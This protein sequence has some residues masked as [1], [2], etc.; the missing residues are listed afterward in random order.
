[1]GFLNRARQRPGGAT[2]RLPPAFARP[3]ELYG[4]WQFDPTGSG[5]DP[6]Q[7]GGGNI[8]YEL[9]MLAQ[10]DSAAFI[11]SGAAIAI[12]AGG[13]ALYGGERAVM[14]SVGTHVSHPDYLD[15][16]DRASEFLRGQ[17]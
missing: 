2:V 14:N 9:Y 7:L 6:S 11:T 15:M 1:M 3:L 17:G 8:E 16:M 13:W 4:R 12:P 5:V 10:P